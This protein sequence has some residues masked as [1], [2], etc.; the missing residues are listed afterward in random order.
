MSNHYDQCATNEREKKQKKVNNEYKEIQK[1][2]DKMSLTMRDLVFMNK[3]TSIIILLNSNYAYSV[4][5][6]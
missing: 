6:Q 2:E 4:D 3:L 5:I 1:C